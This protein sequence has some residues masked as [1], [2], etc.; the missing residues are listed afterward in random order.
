M[1][2]YITLKP[3]FVFEDARGALAQLV[4]DGFKQVNVLLSKRDCRRGN[5]Y[6]K[7]SKEA[8]YVVSGAVEVEFN[9]GEMTENVRFNKGDFFMVEPYVN[10]SMFFP[11]D[12]LMI[13]MYDIPVEKSDGTK[14]IYNAE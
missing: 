12:C 13:Q 11:C 10:H 7:V 4:H 6:H 14:D 9:K 1:S 5:H 3:D 2:L 8:F